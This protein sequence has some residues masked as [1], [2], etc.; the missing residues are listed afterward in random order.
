MAAE[1]SEDDGDYD[2]E[3]A[4]V[5]TQLLLPT[6]TGDTSSPATLSNRVAGL[7]GP[8]EPSLPTIVTRPP[9][10]DQARPDSTML[11]SIPTPVST[12]TST[13]ASAAASA[14]SSASSSN[15]PSSVGPGPNPW[16]APPS[17]RKRRAAEFPKAAKP[18]KRKDAGTRDWSQY[19]EAQVERGVEYSGQGVV[20][21]RPQAAER[22]QRVTEERR[23]EK[24]YSEHDLV[25]APRVAAPAPRPLLGQEK[26]M[27]FRDSDTGAM[28][29]MP[30]F[31]TSF[32]SLGVSLSAT[33][34]RQEAPPE[35]SPLLPR[36]A[37][38]RPA[39]LQRDH[40]RRSP[41]PRRDRYR[42]SPSPRRDY[43]RRTP[44]P[45]RDYSRHTPSPRR[46]PSPSRNYPR[47]RPSP[48]REPQPR[49][50][51]P[52]GR[53][54]NPRPSLPR[55]RDSGWGQ[56]RGNPSE[57]LQARQPEPAWLGAIET[58]D[59]G[60]PLATWG[61]SSSGNSPGPSGPSPTAP[62][63]PPG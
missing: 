45:R 4:G 18:P 46:S 35:S 32:A 11:A 1:A 19:F 60:D 61:A 51:S 41:A 21:A 23:R 33:A 24:E 56:R 28:A 58:R 38:E 16:R 59:A 62:S 49:P 52:R 31:E 37:Q 34:S 14:Y 43:S 9:T 6:A 8:S 30:V 15:F 48:R 25:V 3:W 47:R 40:S 53:V 12:S 55:T 50:P 7:I 39:P 57:P 36:N 44:S 17:N 54:R 26:Q 5:P 63:A 22:S 2:M 10:E 13:S 20:P 27:V 42:R 29:A